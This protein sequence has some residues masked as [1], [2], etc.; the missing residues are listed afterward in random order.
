MAVVRKRKYGGT[1]KKSYKKRRQYYKPKRRYR[2]PRSM[3]QRQILNMTET[4][5]TLNSVPPEALALFHNKG[6]VNGASVIT[7]LLRSNQGVTQYSRIGDKIFAKGLQIKL[8]LYAGTNAQ[9]RYRVMVCSGQRDDTTAVAPPGFWRN[10]SLNRFMDTV[11]VD[12]YKIVYHKTIFVK[13][14]DMSVETTSNL[15]DN[16]KYHKLYIPLNRQIKYLPDG[17]VQVQ[18]DQDNMFLVV[19][20]WRNTTDTD[21]ITVANLEVVWKLYFKDM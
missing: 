4:K 9:M 7:G 20:P 17:S 12:R 15:L 6:T 8:A 1:Y 5:Y 3:V 13:P 11:N 19:I 10:E 16:V 18:Y 14:G 2:R 21:T